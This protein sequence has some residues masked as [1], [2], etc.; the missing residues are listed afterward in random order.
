M[1]GGSDPA[2]TEGELKGS[3]ESTA[4]ELPEQSIQSRSDR[5]TGY[6][7]ARDGV[8]THQR[9]VR[10]RGEPVPS[11]VATATAAFYHTGAGEWE[12]ALARLRAQ[13]REE[14]NKEREPDLCRVVEERIQELDAALLQGEERV[15]AHAA[16]AAWNT[17]LGGTEGTFDF[18]YRNESPTLASGSVR[19]QAVDQLDKG[20]AAAPFAP[21]AADVP[22]APWVNSTS[23]AASREARAALTA[24]SHAQPVRAHAM[25]VDAMVRASPFWREGGVRIDYEAER[26]LDRER[27]RWESVYA[28][29][30]GLQVKEALREGAPIPTA[31]LAVEENYRKLNG[32]PLR[33]PTTGVAPMFDAMAIRGAHLQANAHSQCVLCEKGTCP[34]GSLPCMSILVGGIPLALA[35]H[36]RAR[37][38]AGGTPRQYHIE[39]EF[40]P[41]ATAAVLDLVATGKARI[42][43]SG[44]TR[45]I[46]PV[47]V[48]DSLRFS[49]PPDELA[50]F[51]ALSVEEQ[52][53][54]YR[55]MGNEVIRAA[56]D[57]CTDEAK[58]G[59]A[60]QP[61]AMAAALSQR[62]TDH[63]LRL[64]IDSK[65]SLLND[66]LAS[67]PFS[68]C[69]IT[70]ML[71]HA[72]YG[73][74]MAS[75]DIKSAFHLVPLH[76]KDTSLGGFL[77]PADPS[78]PRRRGEGMDMVELEMLRLWFGL[79]TAPAH[80]STISGEM[81]ATLQ[82]RSRAYA[83]EGEIYFYIF[84]DDLF[85]LAV[86]SQA[87]ADKGY[88]DVLQYLKEIGAEAND[89]AVRPTQR[90]LVL[91]L[92]ADFTKPGGVELSLPEDKAFSCGLLVAVLA[93][94]V[95]EGVRVPV[96]IVEKMIGK[97]G[98]AC[99]VV[100]GG[101][102]HL[103]TLRDALRDLTESGRDGVDLS[104]CDADLDWWQ[105]QLGASSATRLRLTR[106]LA[107]T[108]EVVNVKSD[109]SGDVGAAL[110]V[111]NAAAWWYRWD[112]KTAA[113]DRS[114]QA[115]EIFPFVLF[116]E[117]YGR[118]LRGLTIAYATD[119]AAN[120]YALNSGSI[121]DDEARPL[122]FRAL[123]AADK[124]GFR[125]RAA[126][127]PRENNDL[128]D[129][130]SKAH[131]AEE[132]FAALPAG[133][134]RAQ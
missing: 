78:K 30:T 22:A 91:G 59:R 41:F 26:L 65:A 71:H 99:E 44:T 33:G 118:L 96:Y 20:I 2:V 73:S 63:K 43:P 85:I 1:W 14:I 57:R 61:A 124:H 69:S 9:T 127:N 38:K 117:Q 83:A 107:S 134:I 64:V 66:G 25:D 123:E 84:M 97:L 5:L 46:A 50:R 37:L 68:Y 113:A 54:I 92:V 100:V 111:G 77:W 21:R 40:I 35:P 93:G 98:H 36:G 15:V 24:V 19:A 94:A 121:R 86:S 29:D 80:F 133:F 34:T 31:W 95:A 56:W 101:Q 13:V 104:R 39:D 51:M 47:F 125:I 60:I 52:R 129:R 109:A 126:W 72:R 89:K 132:A 87:V 122:L 42:V 75:V 11:V 55:S 120:A 7:R 79:K 119:N 70:E 45:V 4:I 53:V 12:P 114:I 102:R 67:W 23:L 49:P 76:P 6:T 74:W 88:E 8:G 16:L 18:K 58:L 131:T 90:L 106:T 130:M 115:K 81:A 3:C 62:V 10:T 28:G 32:K 103:I 110:I 27:A 108:G 128:M 112:S 82:R 116:V 48:A 17:Q 105:D